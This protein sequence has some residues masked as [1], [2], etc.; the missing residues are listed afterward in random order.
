MYS[1][2]DFHKPPKLKLRQ[3]CWGVQ[4][5]DQQ[6]NSSKFSYYSTYPTVPVPGVLASGPVP[7]TQYLVQLYCTVE[8]HPK[9]CRY[10][11]LHTL[12]KNSIFHALQSGRTKCPGEP[13]KP[14]KKAR[15]LLFTIH[16]LHRQQCCCSLSPYS[17]LRSDN[18][19]ICWLWHCCRTTQ[20][21][22]VVILR[23]LS[24]RHT[25]AHQ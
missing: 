14:E 13:R 2:P 6:S 24:R 20:L 23:M 21:I 5:H 8:L 19:I 11:L 7:G 18:T 22:P 10:I 15:S 12:P 4:G 1:C 9:K 17:L 16:P 25:V 3:R